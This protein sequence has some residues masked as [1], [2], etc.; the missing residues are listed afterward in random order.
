[1]DTKV[2]HAEKVSQM[3]DALDERLKTRVLLALRYHSLCL[4]SQKMIKQKL[5][6]MLL[7]KALDALRYATVS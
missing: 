1:M 4:N 5:D 2:E 7:V 3:Q 6:R